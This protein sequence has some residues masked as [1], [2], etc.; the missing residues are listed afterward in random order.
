MEQPRRRADTQP[1]KHTNGETALE[2]WLRAEE[3]RA[4][5]LSWRLME[6]SAGCEESNASRAG[7]VSDYLGQ[8]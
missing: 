8:P 6:Y 3:G 5:R 1:D 4:F 2:V 7:C